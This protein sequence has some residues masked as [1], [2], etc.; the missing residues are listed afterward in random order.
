MAQET[1]RPVTVEQMHAQFLREALETR[2]AG[3]RRLADAFDRL[4]GQ[5]GETVQYSRIAEQAYHELSW[6]VANL[7]MERVINEAAG[8]DIARAKGE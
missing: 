1:T 8:A 3:L 5:V 6:G 7:N 2:A 4:A